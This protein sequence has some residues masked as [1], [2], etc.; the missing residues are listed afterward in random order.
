MCYYIIYQI[1]ILLIWLKWWSL[2]S[3]TSTGR[4]SAISNSPAWCKKCV[5]SNL[6][7]TYRKKSIFS[8]CMNTTNANYAKTLNP[9][10]ISSKLMANSLS[11]IKNTK[12]PATYSSIKIFSIAW[13]IMGNFVRN[14]NQRL[15]TLLQAS[16]KSFQ[17]QF[18]SFSI[19][20]WYGSKFPS[21]IFSDILKYSFDSV[22]TFHPI[23]KLLIYGIHS[24]K[25][26]CLIKY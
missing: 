14:I 18:Q 9:I 21:K 20:L 3:G 4:K 8:E 7:Q 2:A 25:M 12:S 24:S 1:I 6:K 19:E 10:A 15:L 22:I 16:L 11:N 17:Q 13:N 23:T 26:H 5:P